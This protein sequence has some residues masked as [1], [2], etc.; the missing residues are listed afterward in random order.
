MIKHVLLAIIVFGTA[1]AAV[2]TTIGTGN[3][4]GPNAEPPMFP[5][6]HS[7]VMHP[8]KDVELE[9]GGVTFVVR[10]DHAE[11]INEEVATST[12]AVVRLVVED[13]IAVYA[14]RTDLV[15]EVGGVTVIGPRGS[16]FKLMD[17]AGLMGKGE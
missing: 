3:E 9:R 4:P 7:G 17:K 6:D 11:L 1:L 8:A 5:I 14:G 13:T 16:V 10:K 15:M 2:V 12:T